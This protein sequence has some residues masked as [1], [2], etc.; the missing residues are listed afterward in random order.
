MLN[1]S[2]IVRISQVLLI[3][4]I[5]INPSITNGQSIY[6]QP[7]KLKEIII[8]KDGLFWQAY[9]KCDVAGMSSFIDEN[10]EFYHDKGGLTIGLESFKK[11]LSS[12]LCANGPQ[13]KRV[14]KEG[15][16]EIFPLNGIGA[17]IRGEHYFYIGNRADG[18]AKFTHVW[19]L[20][21]NEW[22]MS[23]ILSF[24][25]QP[26]PYENQR[27]S[28]SVDDKTLKSYTG[29]YE[30]PQTGEVIF[31][32]LD[33]NLQMKAG[34]MELLLMAEKDNLFFHEK[35]SLTFEFI[36]NQK[37]EVIKVIIRENGEIVEEAIKIK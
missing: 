29:K 1:K 7:E 20:S 5:L 33:G 32:K 24:D 9:N 36:K 18:L 2:R 14:V 27:I 6:D 31:S 10:F 37:Q 15:T 12:G 28:V 8:E 3:V 22:K 16:V 4:L 26:V 13:L 19:K 35:S 34:P 30:A 25:H 17:I 11:G 21:N 23:R